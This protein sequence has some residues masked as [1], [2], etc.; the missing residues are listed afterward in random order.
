MEGVNKVAAVEATD[1]MIAWRSGSIL[2]FKEDCHWRSKKLKP[3]PKR[4]PLRYI[5]RCTDH[6]VEAR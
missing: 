6:A 2:S 3:G 5:L 1:E 4:A